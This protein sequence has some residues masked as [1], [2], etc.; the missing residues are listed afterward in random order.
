MKRSFGAAFATDPLPN[1]GGISYRTDGASTGGTTGAEQT[2]KGM[3]W[4]R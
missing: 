4:M 3:T 1:E 2:E